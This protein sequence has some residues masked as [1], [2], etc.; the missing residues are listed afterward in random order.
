[1]T[2]KIALIAAI[3]LPFWNIPLIAR[4]V[5]RKSSADISLHWALGVWVCF[6]LMAPEAFK[7]SDLVWKTFNIVNL[8]LFSLVIGVVLYYRRK[9]FSNKN[10]ND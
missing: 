6:I 7:S 10:S 2:E 1:M 5:K 3:V 9:K 4:M 8:A